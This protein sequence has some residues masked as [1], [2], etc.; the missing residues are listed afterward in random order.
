M[1][2]GTVQRGVFFVGLGVPNSLAATAYYPGDQID[3]S[4]ADYARLVACGV[5]AD[6]ST[7]VVPFQ[8]GPAQQIVPA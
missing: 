5:I 4:D 7:V 2:S 8:G 1:T 6:P 3:L